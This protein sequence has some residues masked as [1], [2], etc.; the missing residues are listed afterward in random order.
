MAVIENDPVIIDGK[1]CSEATYEQLRQILKQH[2]DITPTLAVITI[3]DDPASAIY[4]KNKVKACRDLGI[5]DYQVKLSETITE[6]EVEQEIVDLNNN[7]E[8]DGIMLQLPLPKHL[9][10]TVLSMMIDENKDVDCVNPRNVGLLSKDYNALLPCT[11]R[12]IDIML[13]AYNIPIEG[14]HVVIVGRSDIVGK[15]L[16][17]LLTNENAT[18]TL[19][20][21]YT[22]DLKKI[23]KTADILITAIGKPKYFTN[24]YIKRGAVVIDCGMNHD[25]NGKLCGDVDF[26]D[27]KGL[28]S[29]ITPVP[30]GVGK[31]TVASLMF[32]IVMCAIL[33][34][35]RRKRM[36][37]E[38][39]KSGSAGKVVE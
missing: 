31:M 35:K 1:F 22:A 11:P 34:D 28:T 10:P 27:V 12:G 29:F 18:V 17:M 20:H 19:C 33:Q 5:E 36:F 2:Q 13:H 3:G 6:E 23:C 15:P 38:T 30:N 7:D 4:V 37:E 8:I 21:S 9:N 26:D 24:S 25:E 39:E 32:N 14:K 16:A